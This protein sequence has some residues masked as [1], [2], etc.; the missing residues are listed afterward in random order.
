VSS[1]ISPASTGVFRVAWGV[2]PGEIPAQGEIPGGVIDRSPRPCAVVPLLRVF[3]VF[4]DDSQ[5]SA[6]YLTNSKMIRR[7]GSEFVAG[8]MNGWQTMTP[9]A[10]TWRKN[11]R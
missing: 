6:R 2:S 11:G 4:G 7:T 8:M 5:W 3:P 9:Q 10:N 1:S